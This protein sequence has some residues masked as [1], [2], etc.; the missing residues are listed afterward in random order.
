M[1]DEKKEIQLNSKFWQE[2]SQK[3]N[4][5][6]LRGQV[7]PLDSAEAGPI[8]KYLREY[9]GAKN[10]KIISEKEFQNNTKSKK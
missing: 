5:C 2:Y 3:T 9:R 4:Y 10:L 8:A 6:N 7:N 1:T